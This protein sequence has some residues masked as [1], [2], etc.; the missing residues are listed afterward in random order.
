MEVALVAT[1]AGATCEFPLLQPAMR[2][3]RS[4]TNPRI[5]P[6]DIRL[7]EKRTSKTRAFFPE[8]HG[9]P[10]FGAIA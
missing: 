3:L 7:L 2:R 8:E 5:R 4:G 9:G 1:L 6:R 10:Y